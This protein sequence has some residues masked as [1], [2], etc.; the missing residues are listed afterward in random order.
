MPRIRFKKGLTFWLNGKQHEIVKCFGIS[1]FQVIDKTTSTIYEYSEEALC[2]FL[3]DS[4]LTF[5]ENIIQDKKNHKTDYQG[6]DFSQIDSSLKES[7]K[8]KFKYVQRYLKS[9]EIKRN[10]ECL[11]PI[12]KEVAEKIIDDNPPHWT[13]FYRWIKKYESSG[14][15]IRCLVDKEIGKG[16]RQELDTEVSNIIQSVIN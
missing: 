6:A 9:F 7:A 13:T 10:Q 14:G 12:I 2:K 5:D 4:K 8:R 16:A 1:D 11:T 15:N 3:F